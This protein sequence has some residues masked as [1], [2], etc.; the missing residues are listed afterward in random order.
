MEKL[1]NM[2]LSLYNEN[3]PYVIQLALR[4]LLALLYF[5]FLYIPYYVISTSIGDFSNNFY[6]FKFDT[7]YIL[8][9]FILLFGAIILPILGIEKF[10]KLIRVLQFVLPLI[11]LLIVLL[12]IR[13]ERNDIAGVSGVSL[14]YGLG[15]FLQLIIVIMNWFIAFKVK[16]VDTVL[17]HIIPDYFYSTT[18]TSNPVVANVEVLKEEVKEIVKE[19]I[20]EEPINEVIVEEPINEVIV[21]EPI[22]E[23]I[24][25]EPI[26][27]E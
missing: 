25:E 20:V 17:K 26:K 8:I 19:I 6:A 5:F 11:I 12:L 16:L 18:S 27:E 3:R 7:I 14:R 2:C 4:S 10:D 23:V 22:N 9:W 21:E 15:F 24:V 1:K 13:T